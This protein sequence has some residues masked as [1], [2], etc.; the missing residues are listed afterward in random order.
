LKNFLIINFMNFKNIRVTIFGLG[1]HGGGLGAV[2]WLMKKGAKLLISDFKDEQYLAS[3]I[4]IINAQYKKL[5]QQKHLVHTPIWHLG[6][7]KHS[8]A[9]VKR[10]EFL[11]ITPDM[12][13]TSPVFK[14]AKKYQVPFRIA[15]TAMFIENSH[16]PLIGITG[17]RGKTTTTK[18][19]G[20]MLIKFD[21]RTVVAGNLRVSPL[22][23]LDL[24]KKYLPNLPWVVL[25][26]SSWQVEGL[27]QVK[28]N[29]KIA[30]IT[31]L[32]PD[33]LNRYRGFSDYIKA[34]AIILAYQNKDD[35]A[36]LNYD[37]TQVKKLAKSAKGKVYWFSKN[38]LPKNLSGAYLEKD[39]LWFTDNNI[40]KQII[41]RSDYSLLGNYQTE[42][43]LAALIVAQIIGV[44]SVKIRSVLKKFTGVAGR[45]ELVRKI[46]NVEFYNDTA[47]T[48][49]EATVA[50]LEALQ[51]RV[52]NYESRIKSRG[53]RDIV[54]ILG[55]SDKGLSFKELMKLVKN[56]CQAIVFLP[57][58]ASEKMKKHLT[59]FKRPMISADSMIEA[60]KEAHLLVNKNGIV[61]LSPAAASFGMFKNSY[62][63]G[64]QFNKIVKSLK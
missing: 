37:N 29:P 5:K 52:T 59:D 26:L 17:T 45:L 46:N 35:I 48:S 24:E 2:L 19:V 16:Y 8:E 6:V 15:D 3:S 38:K 43:I 64:E 25:E 58:A 34:K 39:W 11:V 13:R 27:V 12:P 33:H 41:K 50:A 44:D 54:I 36:V 20:E 21:P 49:P 53:S 62:E 61:L 57:G 1:L 18:L 31:N 47:A 40:S 14:W 63:R 30:V 4:K 23:Y 28:K 56:Q 7:S 10:A 60:I 32:Y 9:E 22:P 42:N 55:G 51:G